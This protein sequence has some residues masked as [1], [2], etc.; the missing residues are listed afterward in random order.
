MIRFEFPFPRR[1]AIEAGI[2]VALGAVLILGGPALLSD[3]RMGLLAKFLTYAMVAL[4]IDLAWG[5][6]GMLSLGHGVFFG[7][8]AYALAMHMKLE[9][10]KDG[11]PDFMGW[12]GLRELPWFWAPFGQGWFSLVMVIALPAI[13]A[14]ALGLLVFRGRVQ[15]VYFSI[16][17]QALALIATLLFVGQQPFTGGTNGLTNFSTL[18]G[19]SLTDPDVQ[20]GLFSLTVV[21][22]ALVYGTLR[23]FTSSRAGQVLIGIRDHEDRLRFFGYDLAMVKLGV[24]MLS[25]AIAGVAGALFVAQVGIISPAN[26]GIVPSIE[27]VIWVAVGGRGSLI[28]PVVGALLVNSAKSGL[29]ESFPDI[30]QYFLGTLFIGSVVLFP[31]GL[32]GAVTQIWQRFT[33]NRARLQLVAPSEPSEVGPRPIK[34]TAEVNS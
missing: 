4:A 19:F 23:W 24:F 31:Q 25:A 30:W 12:S 32:A 20:H 27:M 13:L 14:A 33:S 8:G 2:I 17:T 5:Y 22:L 29:S 26:M 18:F 6:A 21:L 7:L 34:R 10:A 15:G 3:F 28:G 11:L 16:I 9:A 1:P